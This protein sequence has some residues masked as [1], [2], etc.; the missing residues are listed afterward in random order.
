MLCKAGSDGGL[1]SRTKETRGMKACYYGKCK[2]RG[3]CI[4]K[5]KIKAL[6]KTV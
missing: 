3:S 4:L 5:E 2:R 1:G 6:N